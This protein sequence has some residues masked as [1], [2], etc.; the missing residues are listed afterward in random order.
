MSPVDQA[1][2]AALDVEHGV[3][4]GYGLVSA[5]SPFDVNDLVAAAM[6]E[7]RDRRDE[8]TDMLLG[9]GVDAPPAAPGY[10]LP[11]TL[12]TPTDA[13][14]LAVRMERD[15]AVAWRAVLEQ[16]DTDG[17]REFALRALSACAVTAARWNAVA[18]VSPV[19]EAFP[20]GS[21]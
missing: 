15:A 6:R 17:D 16:A 19:S 7:H 2:S 9:R 12:R 4:Y 3:I 11:I 14:Q 21:E 8:L 18:G 5:H 13:A 20:G 1:L 10:E